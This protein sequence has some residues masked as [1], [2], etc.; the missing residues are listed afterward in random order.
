MD[1]DYKRAAQEYRRKYG[2]SDDIKLK[3]QD[4]PD[5]PIEAARLRSV[6]VLSAIFSISTAI[7]GFSVE[8]IIFIPL[9]FQFLTAFTATAIFNINST[10]MIDLYPAKPASATAINNLVRCTLG[11][12]GVGL[13]DIS[14]SAIEE[15]L[16]FIILASISAFSVILVVIEQKY[17]MQWRIERLNRQARGK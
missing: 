11:G 3:Q 2:L 14:I 12:I 5:F 4:F 17:G 6:Y 16:T 9:T 10:L 1:R 8:W 13:V 7:Y 15:K